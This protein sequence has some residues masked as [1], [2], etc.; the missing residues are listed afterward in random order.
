[1]KSIVLKG[2]L[3]LNLFEVIFGNICPFEEGALG[4]KQFYKLS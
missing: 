3:S 1:M 4:I 2:F